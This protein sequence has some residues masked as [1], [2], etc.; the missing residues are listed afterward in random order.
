VSGVLLR[1]FLVEAFSF[2]EYLVAGV[3]MFLLRRLLR[4]VPCWWTLWRPAEASSCLSYSL[5]ECL[6]VGVSAVL[7][8]IFWLGRLIAQESLC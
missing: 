3:I 8:S 7:R 4:E 1:N 2:E 5:E 6:V